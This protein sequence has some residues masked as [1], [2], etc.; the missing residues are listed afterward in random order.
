[1][2]TTFAAGDLNLVH[3]PRGATFRG[4]PDGYP[5]QAIIDILFR[6]LQVVNLLQVH[7]ERRAAIKVTSEPRCGIGSDP[8]RAMQNDLH[9]YRQ[10]ARLLIGAPCRDRFVHG[11][12]GIIDINAACS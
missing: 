7:Q 1:M 2:Y 5:R 12:W 10:H 6:S 11:A 4:S 3:R 8:T 9:R